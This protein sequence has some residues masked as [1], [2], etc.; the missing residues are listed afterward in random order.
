MVKSSINHWMVL[1]RLNHSF[2]AP[3]FTH[4]CRG[5]IPY[6]P[7]TQ[8]AALGTRQLLQEVL[9]W[10]AG[11]RNLLRPWVTGWP[12]MDQK[13]PI[14]GDINISSHFYLIGL[15]NYMQREV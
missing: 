11:E 13:P 3:Y 7:R 12:S 14:L 6:D 10:P 15:S 9:A 2:K 5:T 8:S 4:F 1:N